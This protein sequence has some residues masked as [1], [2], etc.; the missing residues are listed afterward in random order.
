[1]TFFSQQERE[2]PG[3]PRKRS[4]SDLESHWGFGKKSQV[5]KYHG[6]LVSKISQGF[7]IPFK[8]T[9]FGRDHQKMMSQ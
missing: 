5:S 9:G 2:L 1:M 6:E 3:I 8:I 7:K 4:S